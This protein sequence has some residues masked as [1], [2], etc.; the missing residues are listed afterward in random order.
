MEGGS[1]N[2]GAVVKEYDRLI[3]PSLVLWTS[4]KYCPA[5]YEIV[6]S[7]S[8]TKTLKSF[9]SSL[10]SLIRIVECIVQSTKYIVHRRLLIVEE[11]YLIWYNQEVRPFEKGRPV[12]CE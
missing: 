10:I 6:D 1:F 3:S 5:L 2:P 7:T 12:F 11:H 8:N 9:S 4:V